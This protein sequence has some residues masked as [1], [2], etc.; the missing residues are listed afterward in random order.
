MLYFHAYW[1]RKIT[2]PME[3]DYEFLP[4]V[5][6]RRFLGVNVGVN[7]DSIYENTWWGEGEV[8]FYLDGDSKYPTLNG[9]GTEDY[10]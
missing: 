8:K 1:N 5:V 2:S 3:E 6:G 7:A 4:R 10:I 9:T